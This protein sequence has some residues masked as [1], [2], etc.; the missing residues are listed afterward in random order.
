MA[1]KRTSRLIRLLIT[2]QSESQNSFKG[3]L[4][5]LKVS[6]RT[7][8][9]DLQALQEAGIPCYFDRPGQ[10]YRVDNG[11]YMPP[12][13]LTAKE[14]F[15][16]LLLVHKARKVLEVPFSDTVLRGIL[17]IENNLPP[18]T[19]EYCKQRLNNISIHGTC[20]QSKGSIDEQF[21]SL[22]HAIRKRQ[23]LKLTH[24]SKPEQPVVT[25][26][27]SPLHLLYTDS[28]YVMGKMNFS[29]QIQ[30]IKLRDIKEI[31]QTGKCFL[32]EEEFDLS[33]HLGRAWAVVTE[34][35]LYTVK[36]RFAPEIAHDVTSR[37][38]HDTQNVTMEEDGSVLLEF[39]VDG[40]NE[41]TW[42][43]VSFADK[44]EVLAP[45]ALRERIHEIAANMVKRNKIVE[46]RK[47]TQPNKALQ[48]IVSI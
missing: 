31:E 47:T 16:L 41:I 21:E 8:Y 42:W 48:D 2:L 14:A 15:G 26:H 46:R 9:R 3:L 36:L 18:A 30:S 34:G 25:C 19:R 20:A 38:W 27:F 39:R 44:V 32:N 24:S 10:C 23:I 33:D 13:N 17:K 6:R 28:W 43:V 45:E 4:E 7:L 37:Q 1:L 29:R 35:K 5:T 40:L 12:P 11:F 22:Q